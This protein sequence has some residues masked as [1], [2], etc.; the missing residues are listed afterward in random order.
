MHKVQNLEEKNIF[1]T[2]VTSEAFLSLTQNLRVTR[3]QGG[4]Q[5]KL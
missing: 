3:L 2:M 1:G 4:T 5:T